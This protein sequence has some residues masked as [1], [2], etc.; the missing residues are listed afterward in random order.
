[1]AAIDYRALAAKA[2]EE[3]DTSTLD[4]VRKRCLRAEAAWLVL[5]VRH[6]T[7]ENNRARREADRSTL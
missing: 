5:A 2:R 7:V 6:D 3:A 1:M 4:N